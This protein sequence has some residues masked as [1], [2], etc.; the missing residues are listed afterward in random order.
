MRPRTCASALLPMLAGLLALAGV[1]AALWVS[2]PAP[3]HAGEHLC[4]PND[5]RLDC[6]YQQSGGGGDGSF[7]ASLVGRNRLVPDPAGRDCLWVV[8][9][10]AGPNPDFPAA[11][12]AAR[13]N[14]CESESE[15]DMAESIALPEPVPH[16]ESGLGAVGLPLYLE[17]RYEDAP[18]VEGDKALT[19]RDWDP[20]EGTATVAG[21]TDCGRLVIDFRAVHEIDWDDPDYDDDTRLTALHGEPYPGG[22]REIV[23]TYE[24]VA[25]PEITVTTTWAFSYTFQD[26]D[27]SSG[28]L[29]ALQTAIA[30]AEERVAQLEEELPRRE[31]EA[32]AA[33][34]QAEAAEQAA[35]GAVEADGG[36]GVA[37][38]DEGDDPVEADPAVEA[39]K[40]AR[41]NADA[42]A[43]AVEE[44]QETLTRA[45]EELAGLRDRLGAVGGLAPDNAVEGIDRSGTLR[46]L[47]YQFQ[48]MRR[49]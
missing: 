32:A 36:G 26:G 29:E 7:D 47:I 11:V 33:A 6:A 5:S 22:P 16:V 28:G 41:E 20:D 3:A 18:R 31:Q 23:H 30:E 49:G 40:A 12:K 34:E 39:A 42:A 14:L 13:G 43:E 9:D 35:E 38:H 37:P 46:L 8:E 45:E 48:G 17:I 4:G 21:P 15:C 44:T 24:S 2:A 27:A 25:I 1:A 19:L 10:P